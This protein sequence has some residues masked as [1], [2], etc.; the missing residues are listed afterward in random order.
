[1][2]GSMHVSGTY[3]WVKKGGVPGGSRFLRGG[4]FPCQGQGLSRPFS[5]L[6]SVRRM[7]GYGTR[8]AAPQGSTRRRR[9]QGL[10]RTPDHGGIPLERGP[11]LPAPDSLV[12][13]SITAGS[14]RSSP[15]RKCASNS[16]LSSSGKPAAAGIE[17]H[18]YLSS[19]A[20]GRATARPIKSRQYR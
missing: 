6:T 5:D 13:R 12:C 3:R 17:A 19:N 7:T 4:G 20:I 16:S 1:M 10:D 15:R 2:H 8:R 18:L 9:R 11:A 14:S